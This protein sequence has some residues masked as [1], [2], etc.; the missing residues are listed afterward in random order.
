MAR[1]ERAQGEARW[2][3]GARV[4][5]VVSYC[6]PRPASPG[7]NRTNGPTRVRCARPIREATPGRTPAPTQPWTPRR[8]AGRRRR[9]A[10]R[11]P[12]PTSRSARIGSGR[13]SS[14]LRVAPSWMPRWPRCPPSCATPRS[15]TRWPERSNS[16]GP[17]WP[18]MRSPPA[19]WPCC[20]PTGST[21][22]PAFTRRTLHCRPRTSTSRPSCP[23]SSFGVTM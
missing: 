6:W 17:S 4:P 10:F 20:C 13:R 19:R 8:T 11:P 1:P 14:T 12:K 16:N 22:S 23:S 15:P 2:V 7:A 21:T 9:T 5:A 18:S 3:V